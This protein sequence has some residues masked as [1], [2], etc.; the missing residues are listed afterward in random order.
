[1]N[2]VRDRGRFRENKHMKKNQLIVSNN[3]MQKSDDR[4]LSLSGMKKIFLAGVMF[5]VVPFVSF[6]QTGAT[7]TVAVAPVAN[8]TAIADPGLI[9]GDFFYFLDKWSEAFGTSFSF[10]KEKKAR[11]HLEYAKERVA[12][13]KEVLKKSEAKLDDVADIRIDFDERVAKAVN[14]V[15]SEKDKGSDVSDLARELD[16]ELDVSRTALKNIFREHIDRS[17]QAE[18]VIREK[19]SALPADAPQV[20][21]LTQALES[22]TK[23]KGDARKEHDDIDGDFSDE[24]EL[25]EE[26]MGK[27]L[28]AQKHIEQALRLRERLEDALGQ[29]P[30]Q[31]IQLMRQAEE[32]AQRG[33]FEAAKRM[34]KDAERV[35]E[36][37]NKSNEDRPPVEMPMMGETDEMMDDD[38][39]IDESHLNDLEQE[40]KRGESMME[41]FNR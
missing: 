40:I 33:D 20:Q 21:G 41:D 35:I 8:A 28:A 9:P 3:T 30:T 25:F 10:N 31:T 16:D 6:A 4:D 23:E 38:M 11:K 14:L 17:G 5:I 15:K 27:E 22:I 37:I 24:E 18:S 19:L 2:P 29:V 7:G 26:V 12:E 34:S 13:M 32:A 1:M 36:M 39:D